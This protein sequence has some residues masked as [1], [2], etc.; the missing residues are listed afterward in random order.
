MALFGSYPH[1]QI[2]GCPSINLHLNRQLKSIRYPLFP[3]LVSSTI[4]MPRVV[5]AK[6]A[7]IHAQESRAFGSQWVSRHERMAAPATI[8]VVFVPIR[9]CN[10]G[11][12]KVT[13][14]VSRS[15]QFLLINADIALTYN[16]REAYSTEKTAKIS[17]S[18]ACVFLNLCFFLY[19]II[20]FQ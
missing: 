9:T 3:S 1:R 10:L 17:F 14:Y 18:N 11:T 15:A 13:Q 4:E 8:F 6:T 20:Q 7:Q 12:P 5:H 2:D 19:I 16:A